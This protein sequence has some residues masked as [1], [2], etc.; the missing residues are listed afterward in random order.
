MSN[1]I[2]A[3]INQTIDYDTAEIV[4]RSLWDDTGGHRLSGI[5][6]EGRYRIEDVRDRTASKALAESNL[7][8]ARDLL[9]RGSGTRQELDDAERELRLLAEKYP[10][11]D[12]QVELALLLLQQGKCGVDA[13]RDAPSPQGR[14]RRCIPGRLR[15]TV[16]GRIPGHR[17]AQLLVHLVDQ[18]LRAH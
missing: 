6:L 11:S 4:V 8:R 10:A 2:V 15:H 16:P 3:S 5:L 13:S 17:L 12:A 9:S 14:R 1:G 7:A 18:Q